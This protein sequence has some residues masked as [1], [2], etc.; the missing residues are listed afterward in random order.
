MPTVCRPYAESGLGWGELD[1]PQPPCKKQKYPVAVT[2]P[3]TSRGVEVVMCGTQQ[4]PAPAL[5]VL[6]LRREKSKKRPSR[7]IRT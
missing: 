2:Q 6:M 5:E 1:P 4:R 3:H 7:G